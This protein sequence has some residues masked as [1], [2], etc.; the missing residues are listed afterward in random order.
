M[1]RRAFMQKIRDVALA[2]LVVSIFS[3]RLSG[4]AGGQIVRLDPSLDRL[5]PANAHIEKVAGGFG[6]LEG[7]VWV[8][9]GSSGYLLFSDIPANQIK[10]WTPGGN[11]SVFLEKSGFTG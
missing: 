1:E 6:F 8:H 3:L 2:V 11:V 10:K 5:I 9:S 7:P 4:Q